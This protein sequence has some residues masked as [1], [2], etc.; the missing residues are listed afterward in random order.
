M[1]PKEKIIL[2]DC[3]GVLLNWNQAFANWML[4]QKGYHVK[5]HS[6]Y[7]IDKRFDITEKEGYQL[8]KDFNESIDIG[9]LDPLLDSQEYVRKLHNELNYKFIVITTVGNFRLTV[10]FR[11]RNLNKVFGEDVF[12]DIYCL[13]MGSTKHAA[14]SPYK[15]SG[16]IW[17]ED[18]PENAIDGKNLGLDVLFL[19]Q[20]HNHDA[21]LDA[22]KVTS[23]KEI[24]EYVKSKET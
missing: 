23:W 20:P 2:T 13:P 9:F 15:D 19:S 1:L 21:V 12:L 14:L 18:K 6:T 11:K 5:D 16:L 24:Y 17:I 22:P 3:D 10:Y 7:D 8:I 4:N